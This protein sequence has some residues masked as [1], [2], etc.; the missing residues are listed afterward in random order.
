[1]LRP[2]R[3]F[4]SSSCVVAA[5]LAACG[6]EGAGGPAA[7]G[8]D[9]AV[10]LGGPYGG[11]AGAPAA[12]KVRVDGGFLSPEGGVFRADR[13]ATEVVTFAPGPCAGFGA[14][15]MPG[16]VEGPPEGAGTLQG[17]FDVVSLGTGGEI[18][19]GFGENAIVDG[20]GPDFIVFENA[21]YA[22]GDP[23]QI[24]SDLGEVSVSEDGESWTAFPCSPQTPGPP[25]GTCAG[26]RPVLASSANGISP[27]DP[28][29]AGGD[30]YDLAAIGVA[31]AR[32]VRIRD[33]FQTACPESGPR[34]TNYGFDLDAVAILNAK[35]P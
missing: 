12:E 6:D 7:S 2:G 25:F 15:R 26:W 23:S 29:A 4:V 11:D 35:I 24:A 27:F 13:F 8:P 21:F 22:N 32:F 33:L 19:L 31:R 30:V 20:P 34:P 18:V 10:D 28:A 1:M 16:V 5:V 3:L 9:A 17:S 14:A